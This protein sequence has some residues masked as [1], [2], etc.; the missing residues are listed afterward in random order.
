M[1]SSYFPAVVLSNIGL[2][3]VY[4]RNGGFHLGTGKIFNIFQ[5]FKKVAAFIETLKIAHGS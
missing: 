5:H 3:S 4:I 2:M 1:A